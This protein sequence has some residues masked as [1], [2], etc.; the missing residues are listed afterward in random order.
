MNFEEFEDKA[1]LYVLGA[2]EADEMEEF[3][4]SRRQ[5]GK[6]AENYIRECRKLNSIFAL[7]LRP[8]P[9]SPATKEKLMA[10]IREALHQE[11]SELKGIENGRS[12]V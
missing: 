11:G 10:R 9:P 7:S 3:E 2:L 12:E 5:F 1:R 8:T 6:Q 4:A